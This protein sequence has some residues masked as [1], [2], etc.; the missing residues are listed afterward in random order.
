MDAKYQ[1]REDASMLVCDRAAVLQ[2][3]EVSVGLNRQQGT[4]SCCTATSEA[5]QQLS[6]VVVWM[7]LNI[8]ELNLSAHSDA[9]LPLHW[10]CTTTPKN[11]SYKRRNREEKLSTHCG[12][13][14]GNISKASRSGGEQRSIAIAAGSSYVWHARETPV[15]T[16]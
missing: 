14:R 4:R 8:G 16:P 7:V 15:Y 12:V 9:Q 5:C 2:Q 1:T 10:R 13:S 6:T 3:M 11:N